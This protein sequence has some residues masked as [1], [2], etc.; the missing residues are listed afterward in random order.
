MARIHHKRQSAQPA[1]IDAK[2][3]CTAL[4]MRVSTDAQAEEGYSLDAQR[5]KLQSYCHAR[6]WNVCP[7][8]I[9][10]DAGISGTSTDGRKALGE[11][12]AAAKNGLI[13]RV[14]AVK[15]DRI[16]RNVRDF[17][18]IVAELDA[19]GCDLV[20]MAESFDTGTPTGKF[21]LTMFAAMAELEASTITER[22]M[23]GKRQ[24]ATTGGYNGAPIPLGY[25]YAGGVFTPND[26][27]ATVRRIFAE[28][29][30][31]RTLSAIA[32]GLNEDGIATARGGKWYPATVRYVLN[33]G[34]YA[35]LAQ[36]GEVET[37]GEHPSIVE[38]TTYDAAH[39]RLV[40]LRP[41]PTR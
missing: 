22:V 41:G 25:E 36:Y 13:A 39:A 37:D 31:G 30:D 7:D 8:Y 40:A 18:G 17:L 6:G 1:T 12:L 9:Y 24:K 23:S 35:G 34:F 16:A 32:N 33:N 2:P 3:D 29:V 26:N 10:T 4:Y 20:L 38:R 14:V 28:F 15:L 5:D 21:A 19:A 11:M 27:A